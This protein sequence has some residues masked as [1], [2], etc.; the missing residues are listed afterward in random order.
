MPPA[1]KKASPK[2]G[3]PSAGKKG[4]TK[5]KKKPD[6]WDDA[7]RTS[8]NIKAG[9]AQDRLSKATE[10][11]KDRPNAAIKLATH[12][13]EVAKTY[14]GRAAAHDLLA[15]KGVTLLSRIGA[16]L[17]AREVDQKSVG[18]IDARSD[19]VR[20]WDKN[21]DGKLSL[22]EFRIEVRTL[23]P[24]DADVHDIDALFK[25]TDADNSGFLEL[26]ELKVL[27]KH[28]IIAAIEME[29]QAKDVHKRVAELRFIAEQASQVAEHTAEME[30]EES[31]Y[32]TMSK[33]KGETLEEKLGLAFAKLNTNI[34]DIARDWDDSGDNLID[35]K[36]FRQH[37]RKLKGFDQLDDA[38]IDE[39]YDKADGDHS[40]EI[41]LKEVK[42]MLKGLQQA[43]TRHVGNLSDEAELVLSLQKMVK[44][45]QKKLDQLIAED[46]AANP[47]TDPS[48]QEG[49]AAAPS[50]VT[51]PVEVK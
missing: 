26:G 34:S 30:S 43:A 4:A 47:W 40:G 21:G 32:E 33:A 36:E 50:Q 18:K 41:D 25:S 13:V 3:S 1:K 5:K 49:E 11:A 10:N 6:A 15:Y 23:V 28:S 24:K 51:A 38:A 22:T 39:L 37:I 29:E 46:A 31:T 20:E 2:S 12:Y 9:G 27:L 7:P 45:L 48:S 35:K 17:R 16:A 44:A 42:E 14:E 8:V 19:I